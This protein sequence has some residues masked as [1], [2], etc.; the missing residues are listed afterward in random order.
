MD[1]TIDDTRETMNLIVGSPAGTTNIYVNATKEDRE[2][3]NLTSM[4]NV[5]AGEKLVL[6]V[7]SSDNAVAT[8]P[9]T[10]EIKGCGTTNQTPLAV[11]PVGAGTS[12]I[13]FS[14]N[15]GSTATGTF[16][17]S[18]AR[19]RAAVTAPPPSNTAPTVSV[20]GVADKA[21]YE[22]G[23]VPAAGC[24]VVD[25]EDGNSSFLASLSA[26]TGPVSAHGIGSQT[27]SCAYTDGGGLSGSASATYSI[28][29]T[30]GP[31]VTVTGFND[32]DVFELGV[33]TLPT[34]GCDTQDSG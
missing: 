18:T 25:P 17:M 20:T 15:T 27:A 26:I 3:N 30:I 28:V 4:C 21:S 11:T 9:A 24:Q 14:R 13:T 5:K 34:A 23:A 32:G 33:D 1:N 31:E 7:T 16:D 6:N 19:F 8:A 12:D 2:G 10:I 22:I 29:D